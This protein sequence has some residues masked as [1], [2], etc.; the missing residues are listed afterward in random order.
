MPLTPTEEQQHAVDAALSGGSVVI[1]AGAGTGK[2]ATL[3]MI[4]AALPRKRGLYIAFNKALAV[5]AERKFAGTGVVAKTGHSLAYREFGAPR[6]ERLEN[7]K[8]YMHWS[9]RAKLLGVTAKYTLG[10]ASSLQ[11]YITRESVVRLAGDTVTAFCKSA[12]AAITA[13]LVPVPAA[14][15]LDEAG[16]AGLR[17][18]IAATARLY[19]DDIVDQRGEL[20]FTHDHYFKMWQL[21]QPTLPYDFIM[22]DEAQDADPAMLGVLDGQ[23]GSQMIAVGDREQ[24]IYGWRGAVESMDHFGGKRT[25]LTQSFR[26]GDEIADEAN[27]WLGMLGAGIRLK[28][29]PG[30]PSSVWKSERRPE[31]IL[32]RSNIGSIR[33]L[34]EAQKQGILVGIAGRKAPAELRALAKAAKELQEK[35]HTS[36]RDLDIFNSWSEVVAFS[37]AE[38]ADDLA[39]LVRVIEEYGPG[40]IIEAID[41]CVPTADAE[42][43]ISTAHVAK[44]LEWRHVRIADDFYP[45]RK[46]DDGH[47]L[48][49]AREAARLAYV[50][51]TRAQRHL[52]ASGL[53]WAK[54]FTGGI[55]A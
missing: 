52:D 12:A 10:A 31:A 53:D 15:L 11:T 32:T 37:Q 7:S 5:E 19:W 26:F 30:A 6:R 20:P 36:H 45:P 54:T 44:G 2:T 38:E 39:M 55:A 50:A 13:D 48:P 1:E 33:E 9:A 46:D 28:G 24:A 25:E 17:D 3:R 14:L 41:S 27:F 23:T 22:F 49:M 18:Y 16:A 43:V 4:A 21:S 35:G 51:V 29:V 8:K 42:Q 47:Q 40:T 34:L